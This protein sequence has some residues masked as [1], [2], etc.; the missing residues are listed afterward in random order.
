[1]F[2]GDIKL[3]P[4]GNTVVEKGL[5]ITT[6]DNLDFIIRSLRYA[7][8]AFKKRP[9]VGFDLSRYIGEINN[10]DLRVSI[11]TE[12]I[13]YFDNFGLPVNVS[14]TAAG[15]EALALELHSLLDDKRIIAVFNL[16]TG[17][18][19]AEKV[20]EDKKETY[21]KKQDI[22]NPYQKRRV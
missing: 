14:V 17:G 7:E 19:I 3:D 6:E 2:V 5:L 13:D 20:Q 10:P 8:G 22:D 12:L 1:M 4:D 21:D 9:D 18:L 15:T 11:K 16:T